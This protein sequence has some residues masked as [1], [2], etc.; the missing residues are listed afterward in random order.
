MYSGAFTSTGHAVT[1][2]AT[3][4]DGH[5]L[6]PHGHGQLKHHPPYCGSL[7]RQPSLCV[8]FLA[9]EESLKACSLAP[10][11]GC[12]SAYNSVW[13]FLSLKD[14]PEATAF[15]TEDLSEG[16]AMLFHKPDRVQLERGPAGAG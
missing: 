14:V 10:A 12:A 4:P 2:T 11:R 16:G 13:V 7:R 1:A 3:A 9:V 5:D 15:H 8:E 6:R